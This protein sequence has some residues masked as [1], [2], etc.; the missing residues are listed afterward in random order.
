MI[1]SEGKVLSSTDRELNLKS[2]VPFRYGGSD[3]IFCTYDAD[4]NKLTFK[5]DTL[6]NDK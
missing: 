1:T 5:K 4:A 6:N 2:K 3:V